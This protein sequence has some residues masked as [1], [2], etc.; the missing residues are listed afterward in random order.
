[1]RKVMLRGL[2]VV[3]SLVV[4]I[5]ISL[6]TTFV[7]WPLWSWVEQRLGIE[8]IG[9]SAPAQWCFVAAYAVLALAVVGCF[10]GYAYAQR[11]QQ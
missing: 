10:L 2:A 11:T 8:S 1:M 4:A 3:A 7:L 6:V 9:H 5:P